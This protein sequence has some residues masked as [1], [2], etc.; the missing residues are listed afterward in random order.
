MIG[1]FEESDRRGFDAGRVLADPSA[2]DAFSAV[3]DAVRTANTSSDIGQ[4]ALG[5]VRPL[6]QLDVVG[7]SAEQWSALAATD[8]ADVD[9]DRGLVGLRCSL[10]AVRG[11]VVPIGVPASE[12]ERVY[13]GPDS[14]FLL[15]RA[16]R[17]SLGGDRAIDL[18]TG[19]GFLALSLAARFA[20]V[21]GTEVRPDIAAGAELTRRVNPHIEGVTISVHDL[22]RGLRPGRADLVTANAPWVPTTLGGSAGTR[23]FADGGPTGFELPERFLR[24]AADLLAPDGVAVVLCADLE[25]QD[26]RR[27]LHDLL[28]SLGDRYDAEVTP[29]DDDVFPGVG[30]TLTRIVPGLADAR[31]VAVT[32]HHSRR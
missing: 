25:F 20:S 27:P 32:I 4:L 7:L 31:H 9:L 24:T 1:H 23:L 18:G 2:L 14:M 8:A 6:E 19:T 15:R 16:W 11:L 13:L 22:D 10:F 3:V 26:G 12:D 29:S 28:A 30:E 17:S 21:V 5:D